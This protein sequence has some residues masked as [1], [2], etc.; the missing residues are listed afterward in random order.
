MENGLGPS[1]AYNICAYYSFRNR[2]FTIYRRNTENKPLTTVSAFSVNMS[3][4]IRE[5]RNDL[6]HSNRIINEHGN[7]LS[8]NKFV[9]TIL[10]FFLFLI[11]VK[12]NF[13]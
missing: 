1:V 7:F 2:Y 9:D 5:S 12:K 3:E 8:K 10:S 4:I 6:S 13:V 11:N